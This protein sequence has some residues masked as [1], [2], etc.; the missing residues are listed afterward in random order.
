MSLTRKLL[1]ELELTDAAIERIIAAHVDTVD[2]LRQERDEARAAASDRDDLAAQRDA[3]RQEA[4]EHRSI[5]QALR[6]EYDAY[7]LQ[8]TQ[9][10]T[11]TARQDT[12]HAALLRSGANPQAVPLLAQAI[13]TSE[14]DWDE[15]SLRDEAAVIQPLR[16]QFSEFFAVPRALPTDRVTPPVPTGGILTPADIR[17]MSPADVNRHWEQV[18]SALTMA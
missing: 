7:R 17:R 3:L 15:A 10:R 4:E 1:K 5:A 11:A 2:A 9:E 12:L 6:T 13:R 16:A 8:V 14:E 18:R